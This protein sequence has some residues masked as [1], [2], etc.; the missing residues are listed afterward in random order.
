MEVV[1]QETYMSLNE[2]IIQVWF[3]WNFLEKIFEHN[4]NL[5]Q[6]QNPFL[7]YQTV[8]MWIVITKNTSKTEKE[9][10]L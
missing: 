2:N 4:K 8:L 7:F 5:N 10:S 1:K 9:N 3:H 6:I